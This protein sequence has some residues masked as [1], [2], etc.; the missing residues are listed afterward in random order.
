MILPRATAFETMLIVFAGAYCKPQQHPEGVFGG[1]G[2]RL[3]LVC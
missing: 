2:V 3:C 1:S